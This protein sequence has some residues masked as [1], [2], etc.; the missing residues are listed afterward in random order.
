MTDYTIPHPFGGPRFY[1]A[2]VNHMLDEAHEELAHLG[3]FD[4]RAL[5]VVGDTI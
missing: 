5:K 3:C 4:I 2:T 1:D